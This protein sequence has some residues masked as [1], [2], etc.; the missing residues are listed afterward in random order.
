MERWA[1]RGE[2]EGV[3][4]SSKTERKN[5]NTRMV[6]SGL[7]EPS[8]LPPCIRGAVSNCPSMTYIRANS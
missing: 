7:P 8:I 2:L 6:C 3:I 5:V 1:W 4:L